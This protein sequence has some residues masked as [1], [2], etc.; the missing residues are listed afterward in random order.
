MLTLNEIRAYLGID[1]AD[2]FV[3][4][5]LIR[6]R[7]TAE[8]YIT[9]AAGEF[10]DLSDPIAKETALIIIDDLYNERGINDRISG[11]TRKL[12]Q[13]MIAQ[14]KYSRNGGV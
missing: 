10:T 1:Y 12:L 8:R 14:L 9:N 3:E 7:A 2:E 11:S 4:T 5:N 13:S 6:L